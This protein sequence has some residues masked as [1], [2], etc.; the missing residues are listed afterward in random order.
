MRRRDR[1]PAS[2]DSSDLP[3]TLRRRESEY[4]ITDSAAASNVIT[5]VPFVSPE[6]HCLSQIADIIKSVG[7][8]KDLPGKTDILRTMIGL[9]TAIKSTNT[10][11]QSST[12]NALSQLTQLQATFLR[13]VTEAAQIV[14][15]FEGLLSSQA[16]SAPL[17]TLL[18]GDAELD[19]DLA[20]IAEAVRDDQSINAKLVRA[21]HAQQPDLALAQIYSHIAFMTG[22]FT[23]KFTF[24]EQ[25]ANTYSTRYESYFL[26]T[27]D[28]GN[29][30]GTERM[31]FIQNEIQKAIDAI[32]AIQDRFNISHRSFQLK[33]VFSELKTDFCAQVNVFIQTQKFLEETLEKITQMGLIHP[34]TFQQAAVAVDTA[35]VA[36]APSVENTSFPS[37]DEDETDIFTDSASRSES[38]CEETETE[39]D[40]QMPNFI[41]NIR[42]KL[43]GQGGFNLAFVSAEPISS[44]ITAL[45]NYNGH[46]VL[47]ICYKPK[48]P[49]KE[50]VRNAALFQTLNPGLS[51]KAVSFNPSLLQ[52]EIPDTTVLENGA[53]E[54]MRVLITQSLVIAWV[55][56]CIERSIEEISDD[57]MCAGL[58]EC[59]RNKKILVDGC[60]PLNFIKQPDGRL[61]F[62]D[63]GMALGSQS[64]AVLS[65]TSVN[66]LS[67]VNRGGFAE[68]WNNCYRDHPKATLM[69]SALLWIDSHRSANVDIDALPTNMTLLLQLANAYQER[70]DVLPDVQP[71]TSLPQTF[72]FRGVSTVEPAA[73]VVGSA[74][75][76]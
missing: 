28:A 11:H 21:I 76:P 33:A 51:A 13:Q 14:T 16:A 49:T 8:E 30:S 75:S 43:I 50:P 61:V 60:D 56:P 39:L 52:F 57:E 2:S 63:P 46:I 9:H 58:A 64:D 71:I 59:F 65:P 67:V 68:Y 55:S 54:F 35:A 22:D 38:E 41:E 20:Q 3:R 74:C 5:P 53:D 44:E 32:Y 15:Y 10:T 73:E 47:K 29:A 36:A 1:S 17:E 40:E 45:E 62:I 42:W 72:L 12:I 7:A 37:S 34:T 27:M 66:A 69:V 25:T 4:P 19:D 24:A 48:E 23:R 6:T 70:C 18:S 31:T 26:P